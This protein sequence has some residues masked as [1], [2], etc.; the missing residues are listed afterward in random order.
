M[1]GGRAGEHQHSVSTHASANAVQDSQTSPVPL[2]R[3]PCSGPQCS[4][5]GP[6]PSGVPVPS[7]KIVVR[8]WGIVSISVLP[9]ASESQFARF[10]DDWA[11][12]RIGASSLF[13]PPR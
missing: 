4:G 10:E 6:G 12:A 11:A 13:R 2:R 9:A 8:H 7:L 3:A 1:V 5:D